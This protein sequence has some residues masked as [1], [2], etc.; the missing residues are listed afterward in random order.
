MCFR[1]YKKLWKMLPFQT[2]IEKDNVI[3]NSIC[4]YVT[5][6]PND[7]VS[8]CKT[9]PRMIGG[10]AARTPHEAFRMRTFRLFKNTCWPS[11]AV[12]QDKKLNFCQVN[13][14]EQTLI[15]LYSQTLIEIEI[16][17]LI[18]FI[19]VTTGIVYFLFHDFCVW[20]CIVNKRKLLWLI[21]I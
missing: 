2:Q 16:F 17:C 1:V 9:R 21:V 12:K 20:W 6:S 19:N 18:L 5:C 14:C 3:I 4:I 10:A 7:S 11:S 15:Y 13:L 8:L